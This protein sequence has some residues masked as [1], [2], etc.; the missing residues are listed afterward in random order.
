MF[1]NRELANF[2]RYIET[3]P[4]HL[5]GKAPVEGAYDAASGARAHGFGRLERRH[6]MAGGAFDAIGSGGGDPMKAM[7][8]LASKLSAED[9]AEFQRVLCGSAAD[10]NENEGAEDDPPPFKGMPETGAND[11]RRFLGQ[12]RGR[13]DTASPAELKAFQE[14][15][16][17]DTRRPRFLG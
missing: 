16:G 12:Q 17:L 4:R 8:L 11:S 15:N 2:R 3:T 7:A 13:R 10:D 9:W 5:L 6:F 1:S 14:R